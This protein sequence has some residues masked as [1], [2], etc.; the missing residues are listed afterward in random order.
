MDKYS[1]TAQ[2]GFERILADPELAELLASDSLDGQFEP[3][4]L[5]GYQVSTSGKNCGSVCGCDHNKGVGCEGDKG[6]NDDGSL[7][8]KKVG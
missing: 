7:C 2:D 6:Q 1:T 8:P 5:A 4:E 3:L